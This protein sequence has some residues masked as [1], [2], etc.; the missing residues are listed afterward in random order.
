MDI[1]MSKK[2]LNINK[3]IAEKKEIIN[4]EGDMIVPDFKP[5]ILNTISS[6]G[7]ICIYKKD[8]MDGK[9]RIDG[10]VLIYI[11]YL[12]DESSDNIRGLNTSL[13]FSESINIPELKSEMN[14]DLC[15]IVKSIECK[16]INGRKIGIKATVELN[17]KIYSKE[18]I[19]IITNIEDENMQVLSKDIKVN[20]ILGEGTTKAYIKENINI[21]NT[22]NLIEILDTQIRLVDK[23]IKISYNKVL[24][25]SEVEFKIIY[26]TEDGRI[27]KIEARFPLVGFIDIQNIKEENV[28]DITYM[29][30]NIVIK[31]NPV[32][33]HSIYVELEVEINCIAYEETQIKVIEDM[34][35]PGKKVEFVKNVANTISNKKNKKTICNVR[36]K[37]NEKELDEKDIIDVKISPIINRENKLNGKEFIEGELELN[38]IF[39]DRSL[40]S[41][42]TKKINIPFEQT[43]EEIDN[44]ENS[45]VNTTVEVN[46]Q[47]FKNQNGYID[48]NIDL[49]IETNKYENSAIP[50]I[51]DISVVEEEN[52]QDYSV[53]IYVVK[54]GDTLW[55]IAKRFG[56]T[57][58]DIARVNGMEKPDRLKV[59]EK[60]YIPK[61]VLK[62]AKEPIAISA[63]V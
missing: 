32:E 30:K 42:N 2:D 54:N 13:D 45:K 39:T 7:N 52:T 17:I 18:L 44:A 57:V 9:L 15:G 10:N 8:I 4:I 40:A 28:C 47:E 56:S 48:S 3:L 34:Y 62:R 22:D 26:L 38:F 11:M 35:C 50:V 58:D 37:I 51:D 29:I 61:F 12:A 19:N 36:E 1:N 59:G 16:I 41:I 23:D 27:Q 25:K 21:P 5:D 31:P 6:S 20:T 53:V 60:I 14:V 43:I 55:K 46:A 49:I 24:A 33:E 63:N